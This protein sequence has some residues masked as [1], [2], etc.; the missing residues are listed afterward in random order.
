MPGSAQDEIK[1]EVILEPLL[2]AATSD[3]TNRLLLAAYVPLVS[4]RQAQ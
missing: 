2:P 3:L 1:V 4:Q